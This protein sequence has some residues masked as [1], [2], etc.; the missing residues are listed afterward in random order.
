MEKLELL[1]T[2]VGNVQCSSVVENSMAVYKRM[3]HRIIIWSSNSY[4]E[5]M[6]KIIDIRDL[7]IFIPS[8]HYSQ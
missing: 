2:V 7:G 8:K 5:Y 1:C 3:T 6:L 4:S